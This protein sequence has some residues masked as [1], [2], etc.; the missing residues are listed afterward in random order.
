MDDETRADETRADETR[1]D[2]TRAENASTNE[3]LDNRLTSE[4]NS[5]P[6]E[7][8]P[9]AVPASEI[10]VHPKSAVDGTA[11]SSAGV[12]DV[13]V[14]TLL[15]PA[16]VANALFW[17]YVWVDDL[18]LGQAMRS[19]GMNLLIFLFTALPLMAAIYGGIGGWWLYRTTHGRYRF[20]HPVAQVFFQ[21]FWS[22]VSV[23]AGCFA[24]IPFS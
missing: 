7:V 5:D 19:Y 3:R 9:Y 1:A 15:L 11:A 4:R 22:I 16:V 23:T 24:I 12:G 17:G 2:E 10:Q 13:L 21:P 18:W 20:A 6:P 8:N 14:W